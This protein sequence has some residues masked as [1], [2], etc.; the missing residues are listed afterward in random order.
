MRVAWLL[1]FCS[2]ISY[3]Q[4]AREIVSRSLAHNNQNSQIARNYMFVER[5]ETRD[6]DDRN[7]S[8]AGRSRTYDVTMLDGTPYRRLIARDDKALSPSEQRKEEQNFAGN[9]AQRRSE[10]EA[11]RSRRI[12]EWERKRREFQEPL[13]EIPA[14][15]NMRI[16]GEEKVNGE[17]TWV[18][19]AFPRPGYHPGKGFARFFPKVKGR[20]WISKRDYAWVKVEAEVLDTISYGLFLARLQKG[21]H[22]HFEQARIGGDVWVPTRI[23]AAAELRL[24]LFK[25]MNTGY[26]VTYKD[27]RRFEVESHLVGFH[28]LSEPR[29]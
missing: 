11:E 17:D 29:P 26:Q 6:L 9:L 3:A 23:E 16:V 2:A 18:V 12:A 5:T 24:A 7:K 22:L 8:G 14:A 10:T 13:Q 20:F 25:H 1:T 27:Y 15:F 21:S 4:D 19:E 28:E